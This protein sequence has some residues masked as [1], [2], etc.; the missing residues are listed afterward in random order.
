[1]TLHLE[2]RSIVRVIVEV[3]ELNDDETEVVTK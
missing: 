1:M 3:V 2:D